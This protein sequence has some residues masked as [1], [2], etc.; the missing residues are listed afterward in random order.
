MTLGLPWQRI[1][2]GYD[3]TRGGF[4]GLLFMAAAPWLAAWFRRSC[5]PSANQEI[6][7]R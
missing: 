4:L 7:P 5:F 3:V 6:V 1:T 2:E